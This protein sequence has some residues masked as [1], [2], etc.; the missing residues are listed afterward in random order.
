MSRKYRF[1]V[2]F[3]KQYGKGAQTHFKSSRRHN[4]HDCC[5]SIT[6]LSLKKFF[7][8]ICKMLSAYINTFTADD[9][10]CRLN[11]DNFTQQILMQLSKKRKTFSWFYFAFSRSRLNFQHF[12]KKVDPPS[13]RISEITDSQRRAEISI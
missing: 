4:H 12:Q 2:P 9:K 7:L 3:D 11:R 5:S 13:Q 8:L 6:I 10:Y 1:K